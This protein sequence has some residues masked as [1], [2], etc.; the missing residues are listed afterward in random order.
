M[1]NQRRSSDSLGIEKKVGMIDA[2]L[3]TIGAMK[4][5]EWKDYPKDTTFEKIASGLVY[6]G[7]RISPIINGTIWVARGAYGLYYIATH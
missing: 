4:K 1:D 2:S 6:T 7:L 5:R 3:A